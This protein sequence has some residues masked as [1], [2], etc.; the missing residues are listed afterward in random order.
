M[1]FLRAS[2][3]ILCAGLVAMHIANNPQPETLS[4]RI[5]AGDELVFS[6]GVFVRAQ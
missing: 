3:S 5:G 6:S 4:E 2:V 1:N